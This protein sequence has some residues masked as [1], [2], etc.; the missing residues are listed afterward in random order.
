MG[1]FLF[2]KLIRAVDHIKHLPDTVE[3]FS[4]ITKV[5]FCVFVLLA[6]QSLSKESDLEAVVKTLAPALLAELAKMKSPSSSSVASSSSTAHQTKSTMKSNQ[7][8]SSQ[9][10][11]EVSYLTGSSLG[12][13]V[14][15]DTMMV[16]LDSSTSMCLLYHFIKAPSFSSLFIVSYCDPSLCFPLFYQLDK[17]SSSNTVKLQEIYSNLSHND[18]F[19]AVEKFGKIKAV[20][21]LRSK[22]EVC[23]ECDLVS[24]VFVN[25]L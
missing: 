16:R 21:L 1:H 20:V 13:L 2:E 9:Q 18:V 22:Q 14:C 24:A 12:Y 19:T 4:D 11:S 5:F 23:V 7:S 25:S 8:K 15:V 3:S 17:V 10:K 6:V